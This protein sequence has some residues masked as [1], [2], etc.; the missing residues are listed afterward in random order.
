MSYPVQDALFGPPYLGS[1]E[2]ER[3]EAARDQRSRER[4]AAADGDPGGQP[5]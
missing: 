4:E 2:R 1:L 5:S 3:W